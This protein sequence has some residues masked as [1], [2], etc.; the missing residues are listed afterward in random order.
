[1]IKDQQRVSGVLCEPILLLFLVI[2]IL[3]MLLR[4]YG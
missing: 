1:M 2:T 4:T 3:L